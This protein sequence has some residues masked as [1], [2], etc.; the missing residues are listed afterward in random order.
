MVSAGVHDQDLRASV[1][2]LDH[3]GQVMAIIL[4]QASAQDDE[5][6]GIA[7]QGLLD[8][9][10]V[11]GRGYL[12]SGLFHFGSLSGNSGLIRLTVKDLDRILATGLMWS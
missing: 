11:L 4:G 6:K 3:V 8:V 9:L 7:E 12:M 2:L 10:A 1:G 5:V